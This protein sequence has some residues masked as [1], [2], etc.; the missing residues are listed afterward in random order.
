MN[1]QQRRALA[2]RR[3]AEQRIAALEAA[4]QAASDAVIDAQRH[5]DDHARRARAFA[6]LTAR[7]IMRNAVDHHPGARR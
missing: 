2:R 5:P 4:E 1:R 7:D 3:L 6:L